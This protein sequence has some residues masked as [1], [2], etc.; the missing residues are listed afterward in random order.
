MLSDAI[1]VAKST[2]KEKLLQKINNKTKPLGALGRLEEV[3][4]KVAMIQ[5]SEQPQINNPHIVVFAAD[6]GISVTGLVNPYPQEVTAQ[7]VLNF[8]SGGAAINVF[9]RLHHVA[10]KI[11]DAGV[12]FDFVPGAVGG[13]TFIHAKIATGTANYLEAAAMSREQAL[14]AIQKGKDIVY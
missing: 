12:N 3:A 9:C 11:V 6:H 1:N 10:L 14:E 2:F 13:I 5:Q 4:M 8:L 7:M